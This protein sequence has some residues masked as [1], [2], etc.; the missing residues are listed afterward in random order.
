MFTISLSKIVQNLLQSSA[1]WKSGRTGRSLHKAL[2]RTVQWK[3]TA[4][5][6]DRFVPIP[7]NLKK[8][9]KRRVENSEGITLSEISRNH[10]K[11]SEIPVSRREKQK[12]IELVKDTFRT[13]KLGSAADFD[14]C[15]SVSVCK[16]TL[17]YSAMLQLHVDL[18]GRLRV[19][20][21][22][23]PHW[24]LQGIALELLH[25]A[26]NISEQNTVF[27][28]N[29]PSLFIRTRWI[30]RTTVPRTSKI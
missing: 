22:L 27:L 30:T 16:L 7:W 5:S 18:L 23:L 9:T 8:L 29:G 1:A 3:Y 28:G 6:E 19:L 2:P 25:K 15:A 4:T 11:S 21:Q 17:A 14:R 12:E 20:E 13:I 10:Q 26:V 24:S